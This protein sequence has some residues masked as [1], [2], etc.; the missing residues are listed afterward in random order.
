M[1]LSKIMAIALAVA[2]LLTGCWQEEP[3]E[4]PEDVMPPFEA[5]EPEKQKD[6]VL[7]ERFALPYMPGRTLDPMDCADGM[8]QTAGSLLYEGLFRLDGSFEPQPCLCISY[9]HDEA[10]LRYTFELRPGVEFSDGS[11]LTGRD[12][13]ASL[14]RARTSDRYRSR[15]SGVASVSANG[16][17]VTV[18]LNSPNSALP[19][20]LD[21]PVVKS[22]TQES[23]APVGTGPYFYAEEETGAYLIANQ[24]WWKGESQPVDRIAL[25]EAADD[26]AMLYRF[27]SHEVQ[28]ITADLTGVLPVSTTGS[29][30]CADADTPVMQYIGCNTAR[31]PLDSPA[32]RR[33]L[34]AGIER[35][36]VAGAYLSGHGKPAAFPVSPV[37]S[38]Y[39]A[40][41]EEDYSVDGFTAAV[42]ESGYV[43]ERPLT[44]LVNE[45]N[46][47]KK[48]IAAH[49]AES[50]TSGGVPVEVRV[51]P[52]EEY[53]AALAAGDFDLYYGEA[54]LTADWDL[55]S[56]LEPGGRLNYG[57][58]SNP[59]TSRLL[60]EL[61]GAQDR[62][63]AM[64]ALCA[65]LK[66]QAPILPVCFKSTSV[67]TQAKV[68]ES[69][70][71]TAA[72]PFY[73]LGQC[74]IH[75]KE[76]GG[77]A[78]AEPPGS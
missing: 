37:S 25:V 68:V 8:Q 11:P 78:P 70:A 27:S 69:L 14:E 45:E 28:L 41:L 2:C 63:A 55:G 33:A 44:L 29:V 47:F 34:S 6:S 59:D 72:E 52:W 18:T 76:D 67:L 30:G 9:T 1:K 42:A 49:L 71:P 17:S 10:A 22:G 62:T 31:A 32:L 77:A 7:P 74:A 24:A 61:A 4:E 3:P 54:R 58:W 13:K 36:N 73:A 56:L 57:H 48:A 35:A 75:L 12:V 65:H 43:S 5:E 38:L 64:R 66:D 51:L 21:V 53:A 19:A 26:D 40:A 20:L 50:W 46:G 23:A 60:T 39:P 16:D 15:L